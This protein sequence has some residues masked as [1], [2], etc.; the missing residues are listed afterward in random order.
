MT[1]SL[2]LL[3]HISSLCFSVSVYSTRCATCRYTRHFSYYLFCTHQTQTRSLISYC[4]LVSRKKSKEKGVLER[5]ALDEFKFYAVGMRNITKI[6]LSTDGSGRYDVYCVVCV[7]A[8]VC[9]RVYVCIM[10]VCVR[11]YRP[12]CSLPSRANFTNKSMMSYYMACNLII[13]ID[14]YIF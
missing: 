8:C 10:Y 4:Q 12:E 6:S 3:I 7:C 13:I 5:G 1:F 11:V 14:Y 2:C 9:M